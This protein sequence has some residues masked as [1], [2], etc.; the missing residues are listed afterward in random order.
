MTHLS[1]S[2]ASPALPLFLSP[3]PMLVSLN[4]IS[5][6]L[7]PLSLSLSQSRTRSFRL[8]RCQSSLKPL[9]PRSAHWLQYALCS[10]F[11]SWNLLFSSFLHLS[12]SLSHSLSLS[13]SLYISLS[14]SLSRFPF[15]CLVNLLLL[16]CLCQWSGEV[17]NHW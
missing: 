7:F 17:I 8:S 9:A 4:T 11:S 2:L 3:P 15:P 5:Y 6:I 16:P 14:L 12:C 10:R 13:L 1:H